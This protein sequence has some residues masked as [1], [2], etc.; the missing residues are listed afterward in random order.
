MEAAELQRPLDGAQPQQ[1]PPG[2]SGYSKSWK[3][4]TAFKMNE[5]KKLPTSTRTSS[6]HLKLQKHRELVKRVL[7]K[8]AMAGGPVL[9]QPKSGTKRLVKFNKGY[10]ALKQNPDE[11]LV[12][13]ESDSEGE[14]ESRY[15]S[16]SGYSSAEVLL[17]LRWG[18]VP[19]N[20]SESRKYR[21]SKCI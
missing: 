14:F 13:L 7:R 19:R 16:S 1:Q 12:S 17:N 2:P 21:T 20:P 11:S 15:Y 18:Y 3:N 5:K 6:L 10:S 4:E 9:H 8:K